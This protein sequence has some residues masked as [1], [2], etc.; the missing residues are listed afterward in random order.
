MELNSPLRFQHAQFPHGKH[1]EEKIALAG[2]FLDAVE[3]M[4]GQP[5]LDTELK[6]DPVMSVD[7]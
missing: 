5:L 6:P 2:G 4:R 3:V 1:G 7:Q